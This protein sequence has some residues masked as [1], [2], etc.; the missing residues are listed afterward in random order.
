M[1]ILLVDNDEAHAQVLNAA[2]ENAGYSSRWVSDGAQALS[3]LGA[4]MFDGMALNLDLPDLSG[5]EVLRSV[6]RVSAMAIL[7][8]SEETS[9]ETHIRA[10][11]LGGDDYLRKPFHPREFI[12][13]LRAAIRRSGRLPDPVLRYQDIEIDARTCSVHQAGHWVKLTARE[14]RILSLLMTRGGGILPKRDLEI[15]LYGPNEIDRAESNTIEAAI[16]TMRKKL[17]RKLIQNVRG[18]GYRLSGG[19]L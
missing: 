3:L 14:F 9:L 1:R 16:Y 6:R 12:A 8:M 18:L 17:G 19:Q 11:D 10:L 2:L 5:W 7:V 13:R 15:S 4:D